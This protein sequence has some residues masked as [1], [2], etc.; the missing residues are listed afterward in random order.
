MFRKLKATLRD[1]FCNKKQS[2]E[3]ITVD[4]ALLTELFPLWNSDETEIPL[5][6]NIEEVIQKYEEK[7][8]AQLLTKHINIV[9]EENKSSQKGTLPPYKII[10]RNLIFDHISESPTAYV[11]L[12]LSSRIRTSIKC[13]VIENSLFKSDIQNKS[14]K[15]TLQISLIGDVQLKLKQNIFNLVDLLCHVDSSEDNIVE[16]ESNEFEQNSLNIVSGINKGHGGFNTNRFWK[17]SSD[18]IADSI[19]IKQLEEFINQV[20]HEDSYNKLKTLDERIENTTDYDIKDLLEFNYHDKKLIKVAR[21]DLWPLSTKSFIKITDNTIHKLSASS[22]IKIDILGENTIDAIVSQIQGGRFPADP[23]VE[24][25]NIG[26]NF[27]WGPYNH[28]DP[29]G[30]YARENREFFLSLKSYAIERQ[31]KHQEAIANRELLKCEQVLKKGE[32]LSRSWQEKLILLYGCVVSDH[33]I[34]LWRPFIGICTMNAIVATII[35]CFAPATYSDAKFL[36]I[37]LTL[38]NPLSWNLV[39]PANLSLL[40]AFSN[41]GIGIKDL[42]SWLLFVNLCQKVLL[43]LL[44]YEL[45]RVGRRFTVK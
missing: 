5:A 14:V 23:G 2:E 27:Y 24:R 21:S 40:N 18:F 44:I 39:N 1:K 43:Y 22:F 13:L 26:F 37:F 6:R 25:T 45:I 29:E 33:G 12:E 9:P 15:P 16:I 38:F 28:V 10:M 20:K 31:D 41:T 7:Y 19:A 36:Q 17:V 11:Q 34:S 3:K 4:Y 35:V 8:D 42:P 32:P 30:K